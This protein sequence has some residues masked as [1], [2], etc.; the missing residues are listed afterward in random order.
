MKQDASNASDARNTCKR[1]AKIAGVRRSGQFLSKTVTHGTQSVT[2]TVVTIVGLAW[3]AAGWANPSLTAPAFKPA[4]VWV[5]GIVLMFISAFSAWRDEADRADALAGELQAIRDASPQLKVVGQKWVRLHS[6][7]PL[8]YRFNVLGIW[9]ANEPE[10][11]GL[12]ALAKN[13]TVHLDYFRSGETTRL[14]GLT[15]Q[16]VQSID[17]QAIGHTARFPQTDIPANENAAKFL[18]VLQHADVEDECYA[19]SFGP[20]DGQPDGRLKKYRLGPGTYRI[21][22]RFR[23]DNV[24]QEARLTFI[25]HGRERPPELVGVERFDDPAP[26]GP[27]HAPSPDDWEPEHS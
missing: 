5:T 3:Q 24:D 25:N 16:W 19:H 22:I 17:P 1:W 7:Q 9:I 14:F 12:D 18:L 13:V 26:D 6:G 2:G 15:S 8:T 11:R 4:F 10:R 21:D 20:L 23:G 27:S